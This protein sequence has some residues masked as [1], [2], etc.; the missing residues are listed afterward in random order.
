MWLELWFEQSR[1]YTALSHTFSHFLS[2]SLTFNINCWISFEW[3]WCFHTMHTLFIYL[4]LIWKLFVLTWILI[5]S[6]L[7]AILFISKIR[8]KYYCWIFDHGWVYN[9]Y[10]QWMLVDF[11]IFGATIK[12]PQPAVLL[13]LCFLFLL[14]GPIL[15][16]VR[17]GSEE[18]IYGF[19]FLQFSNLLLVCLSK[20]D[21]FIIVECGNVTQRGG[22][23]NI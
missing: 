18:T 13:S 1:R 15:L 8:A 19:R 4:M 11:E 16:A 7:S 9:T 3:S 5:L 14:Q 6:L 2:L 10:N 21:V 12:I 22:K 20:M 23:S 17:C